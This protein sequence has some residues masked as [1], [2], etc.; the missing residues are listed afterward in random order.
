MSE[1]F[2]ATIV[3]L[4]VIAM[5]LSAVPM[6]S[7][8]SLPTGEKSLNPKIDPYLHMMLADEN[9]TGLNTVMSADVEMIS[10]FL[11]TNGDSNARARLEA[12]GVVVR[13]VIGN[14]MTANV[15]LDAINTIA[16]MPEIVCIEGDKPMQLQMDVSRPEIL[17]DDV[18]RALYTSV[19]GTST[20]VTGKG[21]IVGIIDTG[22]DYTHPDFWYLNENGIRES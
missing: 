4:I 19:G 16:N 9:P 12:N 15:P 17:A 3:S 5:L 8:A 13:S 22:I 6:I 10:V 2:K 11:E 20:S 14:I 7:S 1:K 18:Q 21:V